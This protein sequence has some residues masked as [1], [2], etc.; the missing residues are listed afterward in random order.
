MVCQQRLSMAAGF[1]AAV[2][3]CSPALGL[4]SPWVGASHAETRIIADTAG[5]RHRAGVE[6]RLERGW[7]TY[8][9]YPGDAG[10][11]P[12]FDW[13][14]SENLASAAIRWPAPRLIVDE[15]GM[16]SIGYHDDVI[17]PVAIVPIDQPPSSAGEAGDSSVLFF[18][19]ASSLSFFVLWREAPDC[20][21][22]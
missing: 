22:G 11:P 7:K 19:L 21:I 8:W 20:E 10:V 9:R 2:F 3:F 18:T 4:E 14:G 1:V 16:K 6:I 13:T 17:F 5:A 15:T 12:R